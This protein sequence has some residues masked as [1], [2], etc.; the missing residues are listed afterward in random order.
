MHHRLG[1]EL[2]LMLFENRSDGAK[3]RDS[4]PI[5]IIYLP[6]LSHHFYQSDLLHRVEAKLVLFVHIFEKKKNLFRKN[7][8]K[9]PFI[10]L[11]KNI[12]EFFAKKIVGTLVWRGQCTHMLQY[13][14]GPA[15][16]L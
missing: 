9:I 13:I 14:G 3:L 8:K 15:Y 7:T 5:P 12:Y 10:S 2:S 4:I 11:K 1:Q 16:I 6:H